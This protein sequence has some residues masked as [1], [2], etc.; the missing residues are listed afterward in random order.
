MTTIFPAKIKAFHSI[1]TGQ[2]KMFREVVTPVLKQLFGKDYRLH[3]E[4]HV[5]C[6]ARGLRAGYHVFARYLLLTAM[7]FTYRKVRIPKFWFC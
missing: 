6:Y 4:F 3:L 1:C 2:G 5:S 7:C